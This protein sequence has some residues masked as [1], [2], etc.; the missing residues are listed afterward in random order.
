MRRRE[1]TSLEFAE[2]LPTDNNMPHAQTSFRA[3]YHGVRDAVNDLRVEHACHLRGDMHTLTA[4][5]SIVTLAPCCPAL[6]TIRER[7]FFV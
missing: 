7:R 2:W 5:I 1:A 3:D 4:V 6:T